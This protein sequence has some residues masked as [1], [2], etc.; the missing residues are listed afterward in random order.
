[1]PWWI[2]ANVKAIHT[3][4]NDTKPILHQ[5]VEEGPMMTIIMH[6][7]ININLRIIHREDTIN[8][9]DAE[10]AITLSPENAIMIHRSQVMTMMMYPYPYDNCNGGIEGFSYSLH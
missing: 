10:A 5:V 9:I 1:M 7:I 8:T 3:C 4:R 2:G 6:Y